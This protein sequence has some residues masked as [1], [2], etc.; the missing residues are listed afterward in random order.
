M[1]AENDSLNL[2]GITSEHQLVSPVHSQI[3]VKLP[4]VDGLANI[5]RESRISLNHQPSSET[6][7]ESMK[8][9]SHVQINP[10]RTS[11]T[12]GASE[13]MSGLALF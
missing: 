3:K 12:L 8:N 9:E 1:N 7:K 13:K 6:N 11:R 10:Y 5:R 4:D 2:G